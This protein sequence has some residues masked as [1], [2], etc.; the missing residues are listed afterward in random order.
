MSFSELGLHPLVLKALEAFEYTT[1]TPVQSAAIP[2]ALEGRDI[3]ATAETGTGKTAA[4]MLPALTRIAELPRLG[5]AAPRVL[6][7]APTRELAKQV[8]DA[9][10]KYAKFMKLN[11]VDVVGGM[12]YRE[13]LRLLSRPVDV[14]VATPGRLLDHVSRRRIDLEAVEVLILDEADRML[15]MGFLDD[16]ET[17]AKCCPP[18]RQTLLF[19]ATLDRRMA[20]LAGNLLR[21]PERVAVE[22][23]ATS[24]NVEQRL[25]HADDLDHKRRLLQHIAATPEVGKAIIFAATKRDAD[26]LAEEL[27]LAGHAAAA[28][29][30]DMDQG[31]R[32]RTLQRLRTGQ[33]RLLVATDVAAR[34]IDVRDIT[35]VINFDLPR[36]AE[37][38]V[39]RIGRT[40]R[41]GASGIAISFASRAD[42][43]TLFR[44][45]RYTNATLAIH[46]IPG[47]EPQRPFTAGG[48]PPSRNGRPS[49][50]PKPWQ[51]NNNHSGDSKGG[52]PARSARPDHA[53]S[54]NHHGQGRPDHSHARREPHASGKPAHARAKSW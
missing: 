10:R 19:T 21:N 38:Y 37:D 42:R 46:T 29:H 24:I 53:R 9:A 52:H 20:G 18:T 3:L 44:I 45:E 39:H 7:L 4:F 31:K 41:A 27:S 2:P 6:V 49:G 14:L 48:R 34:G 36:S 17:I 16:V 54:D 32:N 13:Q 26:T 35:H 33:V 30:G 8:T 11:I 40:G 25:H 1:A 15:D 12:P 22:S 51:R 28:L 5:V 43:E 50:G 47:L 23:Q